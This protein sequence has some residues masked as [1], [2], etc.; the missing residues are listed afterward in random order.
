MEVLF[1]FLTLGAA[2]GYAVFLGVNIEKGKPWA[3]E[4]ARAISVLDPHSVDQYLYV[5]RPEEDER[6]EKTAQPSSDRLAA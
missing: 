5:K 1:A 2:I 4:I 3:L 6:T